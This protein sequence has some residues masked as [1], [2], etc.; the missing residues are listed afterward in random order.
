MQALLLL[1]VCALSSFGATAAL[2]SPEDL[3][4][5]SIRTRMYVWDSGSQP[6]VADPD[7]VFFDWTVPCSRFSPTVFY[8]ETSSLDCSACSF[9]LD[10]VQLVL[11]EYG[12]ENEK[13]S[14]SLVRARLGKTGDPLFV[15]AP[16]IHQL[17][18]S[19]ALSLRD[20]HGRSYVLHQ[21]TILDF[22]R[23]LDLAEEKGQSVGNISE[24]LNLLLGGQYLESSRKTLAETMNRD[25]YHSNQ[26]WVRAVLRRGHV[27]AGVFLAFGFEDTDALRHLPIETVSSY[28]NSV[29]LNTT[30]AMRHRMGLAAERTLYD[31]FLAE[32]ELGLAYYGGLEHRFSSSTA[33]EHFRKDWSVF[34]R[35]SQL[36][37]PPL[38]QAAMNNCEQRSRNMAAQLMN[39]AITE[40]SDL[41]LVTFGPLHLHGILGGLEK[42]GFSYLLIAPSGADLEIT[43]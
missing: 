33:M 25:D 35:Y 7:D 12:L 18:W 26:D 11:E 42:N 39:F 22:L 15:L 24:T 31:A 41:F 28:I 5:F 29:L 16:A 9:E 38:L 27:D 36:L 19:A 23:I 30:L 17:P 32:Y 43:K 8:N 2:S 13:F 4:Q 40:R 20:I 1:L 3:T 21:S 14:G 34:K 10:L 37:E 6:D